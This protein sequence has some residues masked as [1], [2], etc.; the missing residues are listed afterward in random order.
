MA[1][2]FLFLAPLG[3]PE[4]PE[5]NLPPVFYR[6]SWKKFNIYLKHLKLN[7]YNIVSITKIFLMKIGR[8]LLPMNLQILTLLLD[9]KPFC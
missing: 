9:H 3:L 1:S 2:V 5:V 6:F 4:L 7:L 8:I